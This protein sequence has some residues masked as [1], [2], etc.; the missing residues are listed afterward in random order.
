MPEYAMVQVAKHQW[1]KVFNVY[2][3]LRYLLRIIRILTWLLLSIGRRNLFQP[4]YMI[5]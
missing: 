3:L 1:E 2:G 4:F 5:K